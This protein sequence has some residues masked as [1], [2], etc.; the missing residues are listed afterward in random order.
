ML[1]MIW[2]NVVSPSD[3]ISIAC[4]KLALLL[5]KLMGKSERERPVVGRSM[6]ELMMRS[7]FP[8][9]VAEIYDY[10]PSEDYNKP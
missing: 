7:G 1:D 6:V 8:A 4:F 9:T 10:V 5:L 2:S 3:V